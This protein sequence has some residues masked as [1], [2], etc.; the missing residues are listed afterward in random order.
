MS[1]SLHLARYRPRQVGRMLV[2]MRREWP[3]FAATPGLGTA[4]LLMLAE[5]DTV[6]GGTPMPTRWGLLCGWTSG[7][8]R[9]QF[10]ADGSRL[11]PFLTGAR[12]ALNVS[13]ETVRVTKRDSWWGW[14][15]DTDGVPRFAP[16]EP[17][18]ALT[19]AI[20]EP[21]H[22]GRFTWHN[23]HIVRGAARRPGLVTMIGA[24]DT[25]LARATLT[26]WRSER[27]LTEFAYRSQLHA[28]IQKRARSEPWG[29]DFFFAR[30][31]PLGSSGSWDGQDPLAM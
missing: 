6:A 25:P 10:L 28:A 18:V 24:L 31:R 7:S 14:R 19:Y 4:R 17:V 20:L 3:A 2:A 30:F 27:D 29:H 26:V 9:D 15:P 11:R 13:L 22:I 16:E 21:R 5:L 12:E 1:A 23:L 8:A